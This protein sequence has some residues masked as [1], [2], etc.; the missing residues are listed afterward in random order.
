VSIRRVTSAAAL[1]LVSGVAIAGDCYAEFLSPPNWTCV[2]TFQQVVFTIGGTPPI[3]ARVTVDDTY[4]IFEQ[5][6]ASTPP[7]EITIGFDPIALDLPDGDHV[8]KLMV[9]RGMDIAEDILILVVDRTDPVC[10]VTEPKDGRFV[11]GVVDILGEIDDAHFTHG[12]WTV[13]VDGASVGSGFGQDVWVPWETGALPG[14]S[15]HEIQI[16]AFDDCDNIGTSSPVTVTI[17]VEIRGHVDLGAYYG[18]PEVVDFRVELK[19]QGEIVDT[20]MT[21][22]DEKGDYTV[23]TYNVGHFD[24]VAKPSHW[25]A[26]KRQDIDLVGVVEL[27]WL[28]QVNGDADGSNQIDLWDVVQLLM[29]W[30]TDRVLSDLD[31]TGQ[32]DVLDLNMVL[33]NCGKVG[34]E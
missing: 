20:K 7:P 33:I 16:I 29:E 31:G 13:T 28:F 6:Y 5:L 18:R 12:T 9:W 34:D 4:V 14:G 24:V 3:H 30:D 25:L 15:S 1:L 21:R 26:R 17:G 23:F 22:L 8:L 32:V 19:D 11:S 2:R 27:D 10:W